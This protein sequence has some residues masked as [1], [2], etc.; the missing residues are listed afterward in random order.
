MVLIDSELSLVRQMHIRVQILCRSLFIK[1]HCPLICFA[2]F[3][4]APRRLIEISYLDV[5]VGLPRLVTAVLKALG[6]LF[7]G[8][9]S[10]LELKI[11]LRSRNLTFG[12]PGKKEVK[13]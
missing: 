3:C 6:D 1:F 10:L 12:R 7:V 13:I 4:E 11:L 9:C 2:R 5:R 8:L